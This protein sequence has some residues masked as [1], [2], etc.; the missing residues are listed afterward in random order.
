MASAITS[1]PQTGFMN[2]SRSRS[3]LPPSIISSHSSRPSY[4]GRV[5]SGKVRRLTVS[6]EDAAQQ[7]RDDHVRSDSPLASEESIVQPK[8]RRTLSK[9]SSWMKR[10]S[11]MSSRS[12]SPAPSDGTYSP[13]LAQSVDAKSFSQSSSTAPI[14]GS[15]PVSAGPNK[16]VKRFSSQQQLSVSASTARQLSLPRPATS[17]QR[18]AALQQLEGHWSEVSSIEIPESEQKAT[19]K[20]FFGLR[21]LKSS[22]KANRQSSYDS[23]AIKRI[24]PDSRYIPTLISAKSILTSAMDVD[25]VSDH[26]E[27]ESLDLASRPGSVQ[28][29]S[30]LTS[31]SIARQAYNE[32]PREND[33]QVDGPGNNRPFSLSNFIKRRPSI[34]Q[35][36]G[37]KPVKLVKRNSRRVVSE[38]LRTVSLQNDQSDRE[39]PSKRRQASKEVATKPGA[40]HEHITASLNAPGETPTFPSALVSGNSSLFLDSATHSPNN[41]ISADEFGSNQPI[42]SSASNSASHSPLPTSNQFRRS[43]ASAA[44]SEQL[45]TLVGSD[46]EANRAMNF[47]DDDD[48][49][50]STLFDSLRTRGTRSTS[51]AQKRRIETIFDESPS[52]PV[53]PSPK[54]REI[55]PAAMLHGS[56]LPTNELEIATGL[57][58]SPYLHRPSAKLASRPIYQPLTLGTPSPPINENPSRI[59][60][61][62]FINTPVR[63]I[64]SDRADDGSPT[65]VRIKNRTPLPLQLSP[66]PGMTKA[67]SLGTLEYDDHPVEDDESRWAHF[68]NDSK[69][70]LHEDDPALGAERPP[71]QSGVNSP[72]TSEIGTPKFGP[73]DKE[74][75]K[76]TLSG[77]FNYSEHAPEKSSGNQSPPRPRT[78]HGK[79]DTARGSRTTG[80]RAPSG[81]HARSQSVPVVPG[82]GG[83]RD[84]V[85]TNKFGTWGVGSK[86]VSDEIW[87]DDFDFEDGEVPKSVKNIDEKRV[88]SNLSMRIPQTIREQQVKVVNNI[89]LVRKF[90]LLIED[91]K[92]SRVKAADRN[93]L[94]SPSSTLWQE[95]DA[96]IE[97]ADQEVSDPLFPQRTSPPSS[98]A[99]DDS[100]DESLDLPQWAKS[101]PE[102]ARSQ[103]R[104]RSVLPENDV[105]STPSSQNVQPSPNTT[106]LLNRPRKDSEAMARSVI[107]ALHRR[108]DVAD[109]SL[110]LQPVP[111][112]RKVPFDTNTLRYIV[113][114]VQ[115]LV[116]RVELSLN[117][118]STSTQL[119]DLFKDPAHHDEVE[120]D[121]IDAR[122]KSMDLS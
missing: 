53:K 110:T 68:D 81:L 109:T 41:L 33:S 75:R 98:P 20:Q 65:L 39:R 17:H 55:L 16:L 74:V 79:K 29:D 116:R 87:D 35:S 14:L 119:A 30:Q 107:E 102:P 99:A 58:A 18:S 88:D 92:A 72:L 115:K 77:L 25:N 93:L 96:M 46:N 6:N 31:Q 19:W 122:M 22:T 47:P 38:P 13:A 44:V 67:L 7:R 94:G 28:Y 117:E 9:R 37:K 106:P 82:Q 45:S 5:A 73:E 26:D 83:K 43:N 24:I 11:F 49:D 48:T 8:L 104:R 76:D 60:D 59:D 42:R 63:T 100:F 105:F 97:L 89:E 66:P 57:A 12:P 120:P 90:G 121:D 50:H 54:L 80:R 62:D 108:K 61:F 36:S 118:G 56:Q 40:Q 113:T 101:T 1:P 51:G 21:T 27:L 4:D 112:Q 15:R 70:D 71:P 111:T 2:S 85:V 52:P 84:T 64:R 10:M 114:H 3:P 23:L 32:S 86:G 103:S 95:V 78:V 34:G 69:M 91:L